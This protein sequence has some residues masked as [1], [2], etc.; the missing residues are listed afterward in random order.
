MSSTRR[1]FISGTGKAA[2]AGSFG[3]FAANPDSSMSL[4]NTFIHHVYFW[5]KNPSST[6]DLQKLVKG[7][8]TLTKI[9]YVKMTHIGKPAGTNRD[10]IERSYA[11]SWLMVFE[12][13]EL[14]DRYQTDPIHLKFI[15]DC[16][17]VWSKVIVYDSV[18]V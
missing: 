6:E 13:K 4:K 11:V 10:V 1:E 16:S 18:D 5:L 12:S 17:H 7:L 14:Q 8:E 3:I 9:D 15:E 2:V